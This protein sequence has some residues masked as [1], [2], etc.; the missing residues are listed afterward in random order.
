[1]DEIISCEIHARCAELGMYANSNNATPTQQNMTG[2][3]ANS[4]ATAAVAE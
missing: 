2:N 4:K 1:M 3:G